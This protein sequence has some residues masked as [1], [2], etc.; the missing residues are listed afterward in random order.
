MKVYIVSLAYV[1]A[2]IAIECMKQFYKHLGNIQVEHKVLMNHYPLNKELNDKLL[3]ELFKHYKCDVHDQGANIGLSSGYNYLIEQ[4]NLQDDDIVIGLDLDCWAT[5][6]NFGEALVKVLR[7][8]KSIGWASLQNPHSVKELQERGFTP[9]VVDGVLVHE[10]HQACVN[11]ICAWSGSFLN[12]LGGLK[13]PGKWYGGL[14]SVSYPRVRQLGFKWIYLPTY[15]ESFNSLVE[16]D[17]CYR[18]YKWNYAHLRTT[19]L[20]FES[21]LNENPSRLELK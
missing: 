5:T 18:H 10:A 13:E 16:A 17:G 12:K 19:T 15:T 21:W 20:D 4:C 7:G 3:L 14:E 11:S 6:P 2:R 1:P 8:N 9:H